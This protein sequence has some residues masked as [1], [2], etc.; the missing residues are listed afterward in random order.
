MF[1]HEFSIFHSPPN[2]NQIWNF[3]ENVSTALFIIVSVSKLLFRL[4]SSSLCRARLPKPTGLNYCWCRWP[5]IIYLVDSPISKARSHNQPN[6][7]KAMNWLY[8]IECRLHWVHIRRRFGVCVFVCTIYIR[9]LYTVHF[10]LLEISLIVCRVHK[11]YLCNYSIHTVQVSTGDTKRMDV[12]QKPKWMS[13]KMVPIDARQRRWR[14]KYINVYGYWLNIT[15]TILF[16][17]NWPNKKN[18]LWSSLLTVHLNVKIWLWARSTEIMN[19]I[20]F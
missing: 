10:S 20:S 2:N 14:H 13:N 4:L 5:F 16:Q 15:L 3:A 1:H 18:K 8:N 11:K 17:F 12:C 6:I 9:V 7:Q 19:W